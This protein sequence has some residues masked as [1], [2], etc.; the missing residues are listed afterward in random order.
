M[1]IEVTLKPEVVKA[2]KQ[3]GKPFEKVSI[4]TIVPSTIGLF[5]VKIRHLD[6]FLEYFLHQ[7]KITATPDSLVEDYAGLKHLDDVNKQILQEYYSLFS[8]F[9]RLYENMKDNY[10]D[11][12][13]K[14]RSFVGSKTDKKFRKFLELNNTEDYKEECLA[15][16]DMSGRLI[17]MEEDN[18]LFF[19]MLNQDIISCLTTIITNPV[20]IYFHKKG[21]DFA[22]CSE[23]Y[24]VCYVTTL[25]IGGAYPREAYLFTGFKTEHNT[26]RQ[27]KNMR[28]I[29]PIK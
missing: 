28:K 20:E 9:K 1:S 6:D 11:C 3:S 13:S 19:R 8:L 7:Q 25:K 27:D 17:T 24:G 26:L 4:D 15:I 14:M 21:K 18:V 16:K 23:E 22:F 12:E 29:Y 2:L 10:S 5:H